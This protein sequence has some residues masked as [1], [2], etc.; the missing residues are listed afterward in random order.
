M[1]PVL[2]LDPVEARRSLRGGTHARD[3]SDGT[4]VRADGQRP[5]VLRRRRGAACPRTWIRGATTAGTATTRSR[6]RRLVARLR[7][8]GLPL[9]DICRVL[10]NRRNRPVVDEI[11][12]AHLTRLEDGLADARR[13]LSAARSLLDEESPMTTTRITTT[14]EELG[15]AAARRALRRRHGHRPAHAHRRA[16]RRRRGLV[17]G[18]GH[19]PVPPRRLHGRRGAGRR[20]AGERDR[21]GRA[22]RRGARRPRCRR[23]RSPSSSAGTISPSRWRAAR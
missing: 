16:A 6:R 19:R 12:Q 8:V 10:D 22:G 13:E 7:R 20:G 17:P 2:T 21:A 5:A 1:L 3:R 18:R 9:A 11:L 14:A 23:R 4:R 15:E